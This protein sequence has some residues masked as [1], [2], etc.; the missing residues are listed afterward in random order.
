MEY[1]F[2]IKNTHES[3]IESEFDWLLNTFSK[4]DNYDKY[5]KYEFNTTINDCMSLFYSTITTQL[6]EFNISCRFIKN[7]SNYSSLF[8]ITNHKSNKSKNISINLEHLHVFENSYIIYVYTDS[9]YSIEI[10]PLDKISN[11]IKSLVI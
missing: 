7:I 5:I 1:S 10:L 3:V 6:S 8:T 9:D 4:R 2:E 11:Y